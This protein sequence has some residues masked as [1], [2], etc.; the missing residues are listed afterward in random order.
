MTYSKEVNEIRLMYE[1]LKT[2]HDNFSSI[3]DINDYD[4]RM[5]KSMYRIIEQDMDHYEEA[6]HNITNNYKKIKE[7]IGLKTIRSD[8]K[9]FKNMMT[10][11]YDDLL[12]LNKSINKL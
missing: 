10:R 8:N 3:Y 9:Y 4:E 12:I 7:E 5:I 11:T 2:E 1:N 6:L